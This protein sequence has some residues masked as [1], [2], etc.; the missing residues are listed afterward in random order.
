MPK[1]RTGSYGSARLSAAVA[2][3]APESSTSVWPSGGD[4]A[5]ASFASSPAPPGL[6][7]PPTGWP[8]RPGAAGPVPDDDRL[9]ETLGEL[10]PEK[11]A[12]QIV[13]RTGRRADQET[14]RADR[15]RL[16]NR[17]AGGERGEEGGGEA[18]G[19]RE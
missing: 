12:D 3:C 2:G 4:F 1:S 5:S 13:A 9:A 15:V 18:P 6:F 7:S 19:T 14:D 16:R 8:A 10:L 11:A 17:L